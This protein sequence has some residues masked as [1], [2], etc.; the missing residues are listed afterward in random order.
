[1]CL[2]WIGD[3][4]EALAPYVNGAYPDVPNTGIAEWASAYW[5]G[6]VDRLRAVKAKYD[7]EDVFHF[8]QGLTPS[9]DS[10]R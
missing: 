10:A 2:A 1:V 3:F 4:T 6:H 7:P 9:H 8:E 5:G